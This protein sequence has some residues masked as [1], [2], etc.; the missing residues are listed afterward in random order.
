M[1]YLT[2]LNLIIEHNRPIIS[3]II[4]HNSL[5]LSIFFTKYD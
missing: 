2:K 4:L 1:V 3:I 5:K